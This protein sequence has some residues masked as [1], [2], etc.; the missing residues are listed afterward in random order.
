[1]LFY[2]D[3]NI[4]HKKRC[5]ECFELMKEWRKCFH[6]TVFSLFFSHTRKYCLKN[7]IFTE[8]PTVY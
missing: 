4:E 3:K 8:D 6:K 5:I 1:M 2:N 7:P